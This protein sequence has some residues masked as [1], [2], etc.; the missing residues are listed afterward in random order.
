MSSISSTAG[1]YRQNYKTLPEWRA[2]LD[3][4]RLPIDRGLRLTDEDARRRI[5]IMRLMCDRRLNLQVLS[6][7]LGINFAEEYASE[8]ESLA[9]LEIDGIV[10]RTADAIEVT[11]IGAPLL[12]VV[13]MR[14][15]PY[16][17]AAMTQHS[18]TI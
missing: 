11:P 4:G 3:E 7:L 18:R 2:A 16:V 8:L 6:N 17:T 14:F 9:D 13:A 5:I 15:D 1:T 10:V 12:R